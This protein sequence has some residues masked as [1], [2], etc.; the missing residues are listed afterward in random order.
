EAGDGAQGRAQIMGN[1]ITEGLQFLVDPFQ[2]LRP[3]FAAPGKLQ[4]RSDAGSATV[5]LSGRHISERS[6]DDLCWSWM[7]FRIPL[8]VI[9][10]GEIQGKELLRRRQEMLTSAALR[11]A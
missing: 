8:H 6:L 5:G 9:A 11:S 2:F 3:L 10:R 1:G 7:N 4:M